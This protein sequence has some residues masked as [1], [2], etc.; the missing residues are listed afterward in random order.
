[1][2]RVGNG[3]FWSVLTVNGVGLGAYLWSPPV[4][5]LLLRL[6]FYANG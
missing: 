4:E 1:M 6:C 5:R 3:I 2:E